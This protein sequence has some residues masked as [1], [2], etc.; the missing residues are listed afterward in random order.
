MYR[1]KNVIEKKSALLLVGI[2]TAMVLVLSSCNDDDQVTPEPDNLPSLT[3]VE[4]AAA[5]PSLSILVDALTKFPDLVTLLDSPGTI[6]VFAPDNDAFVAFLAVIGQTELDDI[7]ES[8]LRDVLEYHV[9]TTAAVASSDLSDGQTAETASGEDV[10]VEINGDGVFISGSQVTTP[11]VL[12]TNGIIHIMDD[13]MV[14]PSILPIVGTI[15]APAYFNVNFTTLTAAVLA[16]DPSILDLL[17]SQGPSGNGLTLFAPTNDAFIAAGITELPDQATLDAV[18]SYH[19]I[20]ATLMAAGLPT[21]EAAAPY[22]T[23]TLG[24][25]FYLSNRGGDTGVFINGSTQVTGTDIEGSNGVVHVIDRTL[26]PPSMT[27]AALATELG[28]TKLVEALVEAGLDGIFTEPGTY[29][30]FAPTNDAFDALYTL[31][32]VDGPS[33]IDD[34]TLDA[35]LKY[36]VLGANVFSTDLEDGLEATTLQTGKITVNVTTGGVTLTDL[37]PDN[38]D[39]KVIVTDQLATNG[40]VHAIDAVLLPVNL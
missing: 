37:E 15:V 14:P 20:D 28:F 2:M 24:G 30:V 19:V 16:A 27:I 9:I 33:Q 35:V 31:L 5:E 13:V 21:T 22:K 38:G 11:D 10:T 6:T 26:L 39:A 8:V 34:A 17:L 3:I 36:H 1:I 29:T 7:P 23:K 4:T 32:G 18:L 40:V 25:D 12:A